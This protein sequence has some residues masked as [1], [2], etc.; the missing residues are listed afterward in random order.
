MCAFVCLWLGCPLELIS[1]GLRVIVDLALRINSAAGRSQITEIDVGGGLPVNFASDDVAPSFAEY[2]AVVEAA[3]PGTVFSTVHFVFHLR[4]LFVF[5]CCAFLVVARHVHRLCCA[6]LFDGRFR[7]MT[8]FGRAVIAKAGVIVTRAEY[9]KVAGGKHI[10]LAQAGAD[11]FVR[12]A[13]CLM[14]VLGSC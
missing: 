10:V 9:T 14:S 8:E 13:V 2:R 6:E 1:N 7:L 5:V 3:V 11:L 4:L 12:Y